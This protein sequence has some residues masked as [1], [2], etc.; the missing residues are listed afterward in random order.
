[1][2][3][4][5]SYHNNFFNFHIFFSSGKG[6]YNNRA[7]KMSLFKKG[8]GRAILELKFSYDKPN[9]YIPTCILNLTPG[10]KF[11]T[12]VSSPYHLESKRCKCSSSC[13]HRRH[14]GL[15]DFSAYCSLLTHMK[16]K[17]KAM[18]YKTLCFLKI[19]QSYPY[20][21]LSWIQPRLHRKR[22]MQTHRLRR[23]KFVSTL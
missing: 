3:V 5:C 16:L 21:P 6:L 4:L 12:W 22:N 17:C 1:M 10:Q 8:F 9:L 13:I 2:D 7:F 20:P 19:L 11:E 15:Q 23:A 14:L 18:D